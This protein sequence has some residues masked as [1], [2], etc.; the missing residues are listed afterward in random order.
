[1]GWLKRNAITAA[2]ILLALGALAWA[3][4]RIVLFHEEPNAEGLITIAAT[5]ALA[6]AAAATYRQNAQLVQAANAEVIAANEQARSSAEM[7]RVT[8]AQASDS[9]AQTQATLDMA[10]AAALQADAS[11]ISVAEMQ[12]QRQLANRPWLVLEGRHIDHAG[13]PLGSDYWTIN[14]IGT[15]PA[16]NVCLSAVQTLMHQDRHIEHR[17]MSHS[18]GGIAAGSSW[19]VYLRFNAGDAQR[20][21]CVTDDLGFAEPND[22][23]VGIRYEDWFGNHYRSPGS[24]RDVKPQV[25][26]GQPTEIDAP[27]WL[28]C[29]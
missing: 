9:A 7:A 19:S 21:R 23:I 25:W 26:T 24:Q 14:N 13:G 27:D 3:I 10:K 17:W 22:E 6:A 12:M 18:V 2:L 4:G 16:V 1:M 8:A 28:R 15:G 29:N 11:G 5:I 20:Y